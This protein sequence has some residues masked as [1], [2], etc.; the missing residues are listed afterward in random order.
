MR[1]KRPFV[2]RRH[3]EWFFSH[4]VALAGTKSDIDREL[5]GMSDGTPKLHVTHNQIWK[6]TKRIRCWKFGIRKEKMM[7]DVFTKS[8]HSEK[9]KATKTG[10]AKNNR[11]QVKQVVFL[12]VQ[13]LQLIL[14]Q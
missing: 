8:G 5:Y 12:K 4:H 13:H 2:A 9:K 14:K 11:R 7:H 10:N 1:K 3:E 6:R